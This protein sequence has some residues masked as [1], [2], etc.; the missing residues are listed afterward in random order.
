MRTPGMKTSFTK[1][2]LLK[3]GFEDMARWESVGSTLNHI[4][5]SRPGW[6]RA[7]AFPQALYA[8]CDGDEVLYIGK[9][10]KSLSKRFIGYCNP[11]KSQQTNPKCHERIQKFLKRGREVRIVVLLNEIPLAW[12]E[13]PINVPAGLEDA[14]VAAFNPPWNG[15]GKDRK[16]TETEELEL[17]IT[18]A[19]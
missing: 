17:S 3:V 2:S 7:T 16:L 13:F 5:D 6:R 12:G 1:Q 9:T 10:T 11:V 15:S 19:T 4:G 18:A 14:L 8:F